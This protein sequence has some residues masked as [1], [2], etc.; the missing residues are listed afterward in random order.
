LR[1]QRAALLAYGL[2]AAL[3]A[4]AIWGWAIGLPRLRD[5]GADFAPMAPA[6][7]LAFLLL[8]SAYLA[9]ERGGPKAR[10]VSWIACAVVAVLA[11]L[12]LVEDLGD[13]RL[14]M[15]FEWLLGARG[16]SIYAA[17]WPPS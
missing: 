8:A 1:L 6:A 13:A 11:L 15:N 3:G 9:I 16:G 4:F 2:V 5:F 10:R 17:T 7:A 12:G 14:G